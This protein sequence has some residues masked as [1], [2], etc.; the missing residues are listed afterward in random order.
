ME[1][2]VEAEMAAMVLSY[3]EQQKVANVSIKEIFTPRHIKRTIAASLVGCL[4]ACSGYSL[5]A[6]YGVVILI[7]YA[8]MTFSH[9]RR[10]ADDCPL[11]IEPVS[12]NLTNGK[13]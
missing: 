8:C 6:T 10:S 13:S 1:D 7:Q 4:S 2:L 11:L 5:T 3:G 12:P 9:A